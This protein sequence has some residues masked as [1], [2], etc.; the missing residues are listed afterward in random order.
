[1]MTLRAPA[2]ATI[3]T[4]TLMA[5][6]PTSQSA[7]QDVYEGHGFAMHGDVKYG[8]DFTHFD[9]VN[10]DAP[11]G[12]DVT[13]ARE[14]TFDNLNFLTTS[15][16]I[17]AGIG[18]TLDTLMVSSADEPFTMYC[19]ICET[20]RVPDARDWVEFDLNPN[21]RFH[22]GSPI[23]VADVV[24]S[25]ETFV[26]QNPRYQFYYEDVEQLTAVD[27]DT[28]RF[29]FKRPNAEMPLIL[30]QVIIVSEAAWADRNT[31][32]ITLQPYLTSGPYQVADV[33]AGQSITFSR[34]EDYW[35][36]DH[37]TQIGRNNFGTVTFDYYRDATVAFEAFRAG[38]YDFR[39]ERI[40]KQWAT[41]YDFAEVAAGV[42]IKAEIVDGLPDPMQGWYYNLRRPVF[43]DPIVR[44]ALTYAFD[45]EWTNANIFNDLYARSRSFFG[46]SELEAT[47]LPSEA[48]LALLEPWRDVVPERVFTTQ[49][50]PPSTEGSSLRENLRTAVTLLRD[51]GWAIEDGVLTKAGQQL[52]F[53]IMLRNDPS[54]ERIL[55]PFVE[56]LERIG[57]DVTLRRVDTSQF[58]ERRR[59][60]DFD[61][62]T[63]PLAQSLSPGNEQ[64]GFWGSTA[65]DLPDSSNYTGIA[66]PAID[67]MIDHVVTAESREDLVT[68]TRALDRLL[69]WNHIVIP[70]YHAPVNFIAFWDKFGHPPLEESPLRGFQFMTW[71]IDAEKAASLEERR[72]AAR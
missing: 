33:S 63:I 38:E 61:M 28:V 27:D 4:A 6:A 54:S 3:V 40:A 45:F 34:V 64:I 7:A 8:A 48:E 20:I 47:G 12:G 18:M 68:A 17:E 57:V 37:P 51:D 69:Q 13:L 58:V 32:A 9:Y 15:G 67:A 2:T 60:F 36:A 65:A 46:G 14:G 19:L 23:T 26:S 53:E 1:M 35:A 30:G 10:P 29:D 25:F 52:S 50:D 39:A 31:D 44:E 56:N 16:V 66:D 5:L 21:A 55:L 43:R 24:F 41:G 49:Y 22:D 11:K 71:W 62:L 70:Q 42:V 59:N 72:A